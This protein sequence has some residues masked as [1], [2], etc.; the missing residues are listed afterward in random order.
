M[1]LPLLMTAAFCRPEANASGRS[2][3]KTIAVI[4]VNDTDPLAALSAVSPE[5][6]LPAFD[7]VVLFSANVNYD[8]IADKV[9][10]SCN[11]Q[12]KDILQDRENK[13][14]PL[15]KAGIKVLLGLLGNH[16]LSGISTLSPTRARQL[17]SDV[18]RILD[19]D[20]LDG[21][22]LDDEYTD[23]EAAAKTF[24]ERPDLGFMPQSTL[25]ACRL[26]SAI[27]D[28]IA[29]RT[30][31]GYRY[32]ALYKAV[33]TE[34]RN[35]GEIF[36]YVVNDYGETSDPCSTY[37]GLSRSQA[38]TASWNCSDWSACIPSNPRYAA[39]F[40]LEKI[41]SDGYGALMIYNYSDS[42]SRKLTAVVKKDIEDL[43]RL[44]R[45]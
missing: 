14:R 4:E 22:F 15:Q 18:R 21:V 39:L 19:R 29:G 17:A 38:G 24:T 40:D 12:V 35:C 26:A 34:E 44:L 2:A 5:T 37:P 10:V 33:G 25:N 20:S 36:D 28:S 41:I 27:R 7:Y 13:I 30:I 23:Y 31:V 3:M 1:I 43:C 42:E 11:P 8:S 6:G 45:R 9:F 16:D 32:K